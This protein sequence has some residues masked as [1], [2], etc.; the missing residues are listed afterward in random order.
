MLAAQQIFIVSNRMP[1]STRKTETGVEVKR[2]SGG[3]VSALQ[4]VHSHATAVS[5]WA[6]FLGEADAID[7][8]IESSL[9]FERYLPVPLN[10]ETYHLYYN[11]ACNGGIWPL[12]H[13]FP[14]Y[15]EF[16]VAEWEAYKDVNRAFCDTL[17]PRLRTDDIVWIHDYHLMLLPALIRAQKP[18]VHIG[19][20]HHIPFPAS[21][22]FRILP[23]RME[24]LEGL[25]GADVVGFHTLE[26]ARHFI[27]SVSRLLGY[28]NVGENL[29]YGERLVKV[30]AF[31]LGIDV[32]AFRATAQTET[33]RTRLRELDESYQ[34]RKLILGVDR[35][36]YTKGIKE[37]LLSYQLFLKRN[38]ELRQSTV[39]LQLCVPSRI[40]V[41]WY[42]EMRHE[43]ERI[44]GWINGEFSTT[45]HAPVQYMFQNL[46]LPELAALYR[47]AD[48]CLVTPLRDGLNL[49]C[50]EY[51]ESHDELGG[52]LILSEFAGA[53]EEMGEAILVNP[54][55]IQAGATCIEQALKMSPQERSKRMSVL[56]S[57][58]NEF[59]NRKWA[60]AFI[61]TVEESVDI[62]RRNASSELG[63][64]ELLDIVTRLHGAENVL[65]CFDFEGILTP[66][67]SLRRLELPALSAH[68]LDLL[69]T[70]QEF[71]NF[72]VALVT[73]A[74]RAA[75]DARFYA[76]PFWVVAENGAFV[77]VPSAGSW[78]ELISPDVF[79]PHKA[80]I[81]RVFE[82][83]VKRV[84]GS[85]IE[86]LE[87]SILWHYRDT[88][89]TFANNFALETAHQLNEMLAKTDFRCVIGRRV[90]EVRSGSVTKGTGLEVVCQHRH[91]SLRDILI[92]IGDEKTDDEMYRMRSDQNISINV[93]R[94]SVFSHFLVRGFYDLERVLQ[95]LVKRLRS[96]RAAS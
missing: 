9:L 82:R 19:Y 13:Y 40:D 34:G 46:E 1:L 43:I 7:A 10:K 64:E 55:D 39:F 72:G 96:D 14:N 85:R 44:V 49:V 70:F 58:V 50:K 16:G 32:E 77:R 95:G 38:P 74:S 36:D 93:G 68:L 59:D 27:S 6:G 65:W 62:N 90:L 26:Y 4:P 91:M 42:G 60:Q 52:V 84:P 89:S 54:F 71:E 25:L 37:R 47:R 51:V 21:E 83:C 15:A 23:W 79:E 5:W 73:G 29:F 61:E 81:I 75:C 69:K 31:P 22:V 56:R 48:V 88:R 80:D 92:T 12:F 86:V 57:R 66:Q 63:F 53:A 30:G 2:S 24:V 41:P 87:T 3:L 78:I 8:D 18:D 11:G 20:F 28:E 35:L 45:T 67:G 94:P 76:A 33:Y 17:L